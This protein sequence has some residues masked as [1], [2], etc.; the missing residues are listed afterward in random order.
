MT[1]MP[2]AQ[3]HLRFPHNLEAPSATYNIPMFTRK[4]DRVDV[5]ALEARSV[6]W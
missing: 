4:I 1:P 3:R 2:I 5:A 6:T